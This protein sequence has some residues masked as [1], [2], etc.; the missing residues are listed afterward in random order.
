M[1]KMDAAKIIRFA[2][3]NADGHLDSVDIP[4]Y[5]AKDIHTAL[6]MAVESL[7]NDNYITI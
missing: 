5:N 1:T 3:L 4:T 2:F 7:E 6:V